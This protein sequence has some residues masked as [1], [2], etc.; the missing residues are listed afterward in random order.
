MD[1]VIDPETSD[2]IFLG[3]QGLNHRFIPVNMD[4]G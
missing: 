3:G 1:G 4:L 2:K